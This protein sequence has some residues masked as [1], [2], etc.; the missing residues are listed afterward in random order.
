[1][2]ARVLNVA[3]LCLGASTATYAEQFDTII[4][5]CWADHGH[6][7]MTDC[8]IS[9]ATQAKKHLAHVEN[10]IRAGIAKINGEDYEILGGAVEYKK[11]VSA[12]FEANVK[13]YQQYRREQCS[14][15]FELASVGNG[16]DDNL[17]ACEAQLDIER[18][19]QL[20]AAK[21]WLKD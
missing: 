16:A 8:V 5:E 20:H 3:L 11:K 19:E 6:P 14:F 15:I 18:S 10:E 9:R 1:M 13:S 2:F 17:R 21:W 4:G 7:D 12:K